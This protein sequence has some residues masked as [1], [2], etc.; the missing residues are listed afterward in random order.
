MFWGYGQSYGNSEIAAAFQASLAAGLAL[1]DTAEI[2]GNGASERILGQL[3]RTTERKI[4]IASK[5]MPFPWR[6]SAQSLHVALDASLKRLQVATIDL[7]QIHWPSPLLSIPK[8]MDAMAEAVAAG[9]IRYVGVSNY[10]AHQMRRA[11]TALAQHGVALAS[12]Q[13]E[14]SLFKRAP[15][16]NGVLNACRELGV[17]LIAYSPLAMGLLTGKYGPGTTPSGIRSFTRRFS[18]QN[19]AAIQPVIALA[20]E[21]GAAHGG[22][23][24]GQ[25]AL[26]WLIRRGTLP[27]PGAKNGRQ[28]NENAG[29]LGW[30]LDGEEIERLDVAT[31]PWMQ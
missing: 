16:V 15:E 2:Y 22:K 28:A 23:S 17:T 27:I 9:K 20:Q 12:N 18:K 7:Y 5:Y 19:L 21:I 1:F 26:N 4:I 24:A 8:L 25:V 29:A 30:A 6:L 10:S 11:H 13:V 31:Q 3:A 14:Y